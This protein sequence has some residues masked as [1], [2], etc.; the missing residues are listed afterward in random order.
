MGKL[1]NYK[2]FSDKFKEE[3]NLTLSQISQIEETEYNFHKDYHWNKLPENKQSKT[4]YLNEI[5]RHLNNEQLEAY[6]TFVDN[7]KRLKPD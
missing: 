2:G 1:K 4:A 3:L 6:N 7:L 5:L